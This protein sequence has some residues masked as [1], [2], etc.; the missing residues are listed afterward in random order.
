MNILIQS[1]GAII[2][3]VAF[4][5]IFLTVFQGG[6]T[7]LLSAR[8][9]AI[10]W[11]GFRWL[12]R[13]F[14]DRRALILSY[15]G[16]VLIPFTVAMW[17]LLLNVGFAIIFMPVMG[18]KIVA[19]SGETS[20]GFWPAF[21][22]AAMSLSTLGI[23]DMVA[24]TTFYRLLDTFGALVGFGVLTASLSY[25][26]SVYTSLIRHNSFALTVH[27][28]TGDNGTP[29]EFVSRLGAGGEFTASQTTLSTMATE[30]IT[31]LESHQTYTVLRYFRRGPTYAL[32]RVA[33]LILDS[34]TL[35]QS[36]LDPQRYHPL[37]HSTSFVQL[38]GA[39]YQMVE[40]L[41]DAFLP[42]GLLDEHAASQ[43]D[44]PAWRAHFADAVDALRAE[45]IA[46]LP[47]T[48]QGAD[49]YVEHRRVWQPY[50]SAFSDYLMYTPDEIWHIEGD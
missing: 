39:G 16:P 14:P 12:A 37:L 27:H 3:L 7:S 49:R 10:V 15:A 26:M 45:G 17:V 20:P 22:F 33:Y 19:T 48:A 42:S 24:N 8:L 40:E 18:T 35:M 46:V 32:P 41:G 30:L 36:A 23:G 6:D 47:A 4:V 9:N 28:A 29:G 38:T 43:E 2:V 31:L 21:Y 44:E 5:E 11:R 25:M 13:R 1:I 34:V 50:I